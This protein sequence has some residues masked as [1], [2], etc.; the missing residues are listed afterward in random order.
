[1]LILK[2][3]SRCFIPDPVDVGAFEEDDQVEAPGGICPIVI[4][5]TSGIWLKGSGVGSW[6]MNPDPFP[7]FSIIPARARLVQREIAVGPEMAGDGDRRLDWIFLRMRG[8]VIFSSSLRRSINRSIR[9]SNSG[10]GSRWKQASDYI[11]TSPRRHKTCGGSP[12]F[13]QAFPEGL[14]LAVR[15]RGSGRRALV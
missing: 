3:P 8:P 7:S 14:F 6:L 5:R 4:L 1:M 2:Y 11:V 13:F 10:V 12:C 15:R 9:L